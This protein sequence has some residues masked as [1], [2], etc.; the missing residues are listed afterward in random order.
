MSN[1][2]CEAAPF[3][4]FKGKHKMPIDVVTPAVPGLFLPCSG[5]DGVRGC[6]SLCE[7]LNFVHGQLTKSACKVRI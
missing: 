5:L 7:V 3:D 1:D 6:L 4:V 2:W